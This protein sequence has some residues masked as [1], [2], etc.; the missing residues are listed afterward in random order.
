M[1]PL[2]SRRGWFGTLR[3]I[4]PLLLFAFLPAPA[5]AQELPAGWEQGLFEVRVGSLPAATLMVVV[6][7]QGRV[8]V[9]LRP[10]LELGGTPMELGASGNTVV[11]RAT[12]EGP[13]VTLD[14]AGARVLGADTVTLEPGEL[15][16]AGGEIYLAAPALARVLGAEAQVEWESLSITFSRGTP[17][18]AEALREVESRRRQ[19]LL[20]Q[21]GEVRLGG[22]SVRYR[23]VNGAGVLDW[24]MSG[25]VGS[26][27]AAPALRLG[28][29]FSVAGGML[30]LR[31][32]LAADSG[33][34]GLLDPTVAYHRVFPAGRWIRQLQLGDHL[35]GGLRARSLRGVSIGNAPFYRRTRFDQVLLSPELPPGWQYEVYQG[36]RLVGFSDAAAQRPVAVPLEYGSTPVQVKMYGPA[37]EIRQSSIVYAVPVGQLPAGVTEY[38][39]GGGL[40]P[41]GECDLTGYVDLR[42]GV[43]RTLTLVGGFEYEQ[44]ADTT[45]AA[46][47]FRPYA[48]V[49]ALPRPGT[50]V[51]VQ[52]LARSFVRGSVQHVAAGGVVQGT[53]GVN[54]PGSGQFSFAPLAGPRWQVAGGFS[55]S[56]VRA[57]PLRAFALNGRLEGTAETGM[58]RVRVSAATGFSWMRL[59]GGYE[60]GGPGSPAVVFIQPS[61]SM[62]RFVPRWLRGSGLSGS[63]AM[64]E[65]G[66]RQAALN[67]SVQTGAS[68]Y[69]TVAVQWLPDGQGTA[70]HVGFAR[71]FGFAN[72]QTQAA[73]MRDG[74]E[75]SWSA[76]GSVAYGGARRALPLPHRGTGMAGVGGRVYYDLDGDGRFG[77]GDRPL[78]GIG[79]RIGAVTAR[80]EADGSY[81]V[82]SVL[83]FE[84]ASVALDSL[85]MSDPNWVP[86]RSMEQVRPAPHVFATVDIPLVQT[87]ELA[88]RLVAGRDIPTVGGVTL[89]LVS[90]ETGVS[91]RTVTFSD[92]EYYLSRLRPG[93]YEI[94]VAESSL[95]ALNARA[96]PSPAI[97]VVPSGGESLL[98]EAPVITL[99][100]Q[101]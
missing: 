46:A 57:G 32:T 9:P 60:S 38:S 94:R 80:T 10:V 22:D 31:G 43:T 1:L 77:A 12:P 40:C 18:P 71:R 51:E 91:Q 72:V 101:R 95:R 29:G 41:R 24:A 61:V 64:A 85:S 84:V 59:E 19:E 7:D 98:V 5:R 13:P 23:A 39:A 26:E 4:I 30:T 52:A 8:L 28:S 2:V 88:G 68:S 3:L 6:N 62:P 100:L 17:F 74:V 58:D 44:S 14:V 81:R 55:R 35:G 67:T 63:V 97:I 90:R 86:V 15:L 47:G 73:S 78:E 70:L 36:G 21:A 16:R 76:E 48:A 89:E 50:I 27:S 96:E 92:G 87:R 56:A 79:V 53:A 20:Q 83:P 34:A 11:I 42:R 49:S 33:S 54:W 99:E 65:G 82:W 66:V 69:A 37:G 93:T 25:R 75:G 45:V